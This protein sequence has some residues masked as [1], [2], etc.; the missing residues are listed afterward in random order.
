MRGHGWE[1]TLE[2][3][4]IENNATEEAIAECIEVLI[5]IRLFPKNLLKFRF[6]NVRILYSELSIFVDSYWKFSPQVA[7]RENPKV[8]FN[9]FLYL[10]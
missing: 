4:I 7:V 1:D 3:P 9:V 2:V 6:I 8:G 10:L 5:S